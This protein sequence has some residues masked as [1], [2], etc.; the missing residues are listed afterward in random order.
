MAKVNKKK[1]VDNWKKKKWYIIESDSVFENKEIGKTVALDSKELVGRT[2]KKTL[3]QITNSF[4][5]SAYT[6]LFKI[7]KVTAT[8]AETKL[9]EFNTKP[10]NIKR[11]ARRGKS[12]IDNIIYVTTKDG[13][14]LKLKTLFITGTK[15]T[16]TLRKESRNLIEEYFLNEISTKTLSET[17]NEILNKKI[18]EKL[19]KK[20]VKL[21]YINKIMVVRAKI[22]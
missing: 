13:V 3:D 20:L 9:Q 16:T 22:I 8:K 17:W 2:I 10:G 18:C 6:L 15:F 4:R 1:T 5:D 21:G 14:K 12:K 7:D 19:K 11:L